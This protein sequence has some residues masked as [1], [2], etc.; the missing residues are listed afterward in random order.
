MAHEKCNISHTFQPLIDSC[1]VHSSLCKRAQTKAGH[2]IF[3]EHE[4]NILNEKILERERVCL[5]LLIYLPER[6]DRP[7]EMNLHL[8]ILRAS[9]CLSLSPSLSLSFALCLCLS[10]SLSLS[11][12]M[13]V[14]KFLS[15]RRRSR[16]SRYA[17]THA[18][19]IASTAVLS[20]RVDRR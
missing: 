13:S 12:S 2:L 1:L 15:K 20:Y 11:L 7:C 9:P 8:L 10:F 3:I 6:C 4:L 14:A 19:H 17:K 18:S 5:S 16:I